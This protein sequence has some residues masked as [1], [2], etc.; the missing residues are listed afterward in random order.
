MK[1]FRNDACYIEF[2]DLFN[3]D[4]PIKND[5]CHYDN[6]ELVIVKEPKDIEILK[7]N[8]KIIDYDLVRELTEEELSNMIKKLGDGID[9]IPI[10]ETKSIIQIINKLIDYKT[11]RVEIDSIFEKYYGNQKVLKK[12]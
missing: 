12:Q 11:R 6:D 8:K 10:E 7:N 2:E 1:L 5:K 3:I 4:T 9:D